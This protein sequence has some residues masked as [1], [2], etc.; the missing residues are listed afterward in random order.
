MT[1]DQ[2]EPEDATEPDGIDAYRPLGQRADR[3]LG[4][5]MKEALDYITAH[6]GA[7]KIEVYTNCQGYPNPYGGRDNYLDRLFRRGLIYNLGRCNRAALYAWQVEPK[8]GMWHR[9]HP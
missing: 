7:T 8:P 4:P 2:A 9:S 3:P 6:P 1:D 5:R